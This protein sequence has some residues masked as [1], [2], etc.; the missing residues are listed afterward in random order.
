MTLMAVD[1]KKNTLYFHEH[2]LDFIGTLGKVQILRNYLVN[3][4]G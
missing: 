2:L 4:Y 3:I 1:R